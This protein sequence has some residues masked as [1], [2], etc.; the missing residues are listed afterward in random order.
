MQWGDR[1][2]DSGLLF[3]VCL[4]YGLIF[5]VFVDGK[6]GSCY[7]FDLFKGIFISLAFHKAK[8]LCLAIFEGVKIVDAC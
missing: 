4:F 3:F 7:G 6:S 1:E 2:S 8:V 5:S